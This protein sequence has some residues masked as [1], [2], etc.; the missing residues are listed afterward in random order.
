MP[1][2]L[3]LKLKLLSF[4]G[5]PGC[6]RSRE[7]GFPAG[8]DVEA[9]VEV[10]QER[11]PKVRS[12]LLLKNSVIIFVFTDL[13]RVRGVVGLAEEGAATTHVS[14]RLGRAPVRAGVGGGGLGAGVDI[15]ADADV[16]LPQE[17]AR[18]AE[19][20]LLGLVVRFLGGRTRC[21]VAGCRTLGRRRP[22]GPVVERLQC[23]RP[24]SLEV[25]P[26]QPGKHASLQG[27]EQGLVEFHDF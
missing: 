9:W 20:V 14:D 4:S 12:L 1:S 22:E 18:D 15:P 21:R 16:L 17:V 7:G 2:E 3:E 24:P 13:H 19:H 27:R 6:C 5:L 11:R 10:S 26:G 8:R 25:R 23:Q